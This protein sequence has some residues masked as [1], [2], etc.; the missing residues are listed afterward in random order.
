MWEW[1]ESVKCK[2]KNIKVTIQKT[3]LY[4]NYEGVSLHWTSNAPYVR[5]GAM[6]CKPSWTGAYRMQPFVLDKGLKVSMAV[7][8]D[9]MKFDTVLETRRNYKIRYQMTKLNYNY[10]ES[11]NFN[12]IR[13]TNHIFLREFWPFIK[14]EWKKYK[15]IDAPT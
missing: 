14:L 13:E 2:R 11:M 5:I 9:I 15:E 8:I 7:I 3:I 10:K 12:C 6:E 1:F 4:I